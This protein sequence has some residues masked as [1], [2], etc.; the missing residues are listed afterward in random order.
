MAGT[1]QDG[2]ARIF[3]KL[4]MRLGKLAKKKLRA[5]GGFDEARVHAIGAETEVGGRILF[6]E[7]GGHRR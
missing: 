4:R 5:S 2:E 1:A 6:C 7:I 3:R